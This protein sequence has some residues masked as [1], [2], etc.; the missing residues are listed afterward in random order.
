[1]SFLAELP[2]ILAQVFFFALWGIIMYMAFTSCTSSER[3][4]ATVLVLVYVGLHL[5]SVNSGIRFSFDPMF[6]LP[7]RLYLKDVVIPITS[8][9]LAILLGGEGMWWGTI[10]SL[11]VNAIALAMIIPGFLHF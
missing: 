9:G 5:L 11:I 7:F 6:D 1:M 8:L 2:N 3:A 10:Y 4:T